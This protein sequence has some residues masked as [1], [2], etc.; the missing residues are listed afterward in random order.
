MAE[1]LLIA[2]LIAAPLCA[3]AAAG[4]TA[5]RLAERQSQ[6]HCL[7][8]ESTM[9][10]PAQPAWGPTRTTLIQARAPISKATAAWGDSG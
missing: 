2:L 1:A 10:R 4:Q 9:I 8:C 3:M 7:L 5:A 6:F